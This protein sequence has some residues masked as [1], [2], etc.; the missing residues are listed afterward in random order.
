MAPLRYLCLLLPL[1]ACND[2]DY[3]RVAGHTQESFSN[4]ADIL[5]VVD[6]STSMSEEA[7]ALA[8]NFDQFITLLAERDVAASDGQD[9]LSDAVTDYVDFVGNQVSFID[10]QIGIT[11]TDVTEDQGDLLGSP[12]VIDGDTN[13]IAASFTGNLVCDSACIPG[14]TL[15]EDSGY[16]CGDPL[17]DSVSEEF[18]DCACDS[19]YENHCATSGDE[20]PIEAVFLALC[21]AVEDPPEE[22]FDEAFSEFDSG[23][24]ES[25]KRWLRDDSS[26]I[27]VII[28]D[29]GDQSRRAERG[30]VD[31]EV[32][33]ELFDKF[34]RRI[35]FAVIGP[36]HP[37]C[38]DGA[39][40]WGVD[41]LKH[42]VD[43]TA[44]LWVN[45]AEPD[46]ADI[47]EQT[48]FFQALEQLGELLRSLLEA[49]PLQTVPDIDTLVVVI[50]GVP[51]DKAEDTDAGFGDGWTYRAEDNSVVL[52]G[53]AVP[54][55]NQEVRIYYKPLE[56][57]P[58]ELP[59]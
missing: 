43:T 18:V 9:G 49:F 33:D 19:P 17:T 31:E 27:P 51:V 5:F 56:G 42:Y 44:G 37:R 11:T 58:R 46:A 2:Y 8:V 7:T 32:Y 36:G 3:F 13:D 38:D 10:Y 57:M 47:C 6:N 12:R 50:D 41:R 55:P 28:T 45:I 24:V 26:V 21:R 22:C 20:E 15:V 40:N 29:E 14:N 25:N 53:S 39:A 52:H 1:V 48:D 34:R 35:S 4:K 16:K 59:F 54:D 23:W 30:Q